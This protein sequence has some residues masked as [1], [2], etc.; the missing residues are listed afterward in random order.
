[1]TY[2]KNGPKEARQKILLHLSEKWSARKSSSSQDL[3]Y[4]NA[5]TTNPYCITS[6]PALTRPF[7][8]AS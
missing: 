6:I 1:M 7:E 5:D 4:K 8:A 2:C 3:L